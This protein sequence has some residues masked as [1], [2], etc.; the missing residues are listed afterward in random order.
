MSESFETTK[1][2]TRMDTNGMTLNS[3]RHIA[4][5]RK[6]A[7]ES[8]RKYNLKERDLWGDPEQNA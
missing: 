8:G 5:R 2:D 3:T 6:T 1:F 4:N 7:K